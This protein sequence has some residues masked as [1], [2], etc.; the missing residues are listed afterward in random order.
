MNEAARN[1]ITRAMQ[2]IEEHCSQEDGPTIAELNDY[3][4]DHGN[5]IEGDSVYHDCQLAWRWM[6]RALKE[7]AE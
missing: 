3:V 6:E 4:N 7:G 1:A 2:A 5:P